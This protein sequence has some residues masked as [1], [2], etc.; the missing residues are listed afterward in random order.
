MWARIVHFL[1]MLFSEAIE[2][3]GEGVKQT[4]HEGSAQ[5]INDDKIYSRKD[6][7]LQ[8]NLGTFETIPSQQR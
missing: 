5:N 4:P 6:M 3:L 8:P 1:V 2:D 7:G